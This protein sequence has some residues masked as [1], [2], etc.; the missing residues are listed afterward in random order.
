MKYP[1]EPE[2]TAAAAKHGLDPD[3][4]AAICW[5]ESEFKPEA[6]RYEGR[7]ERRYIDF[8]TKY[9]TLPENIQDMLASSHGL[10][11]VMGLTACELGLNPLDLDQLYIPETGLE[12][13]CQY[14]AKLIKKY[15]SNPQPGAAVLQGK[16]LEAVIAA[17]NAGSPRKGPKGLGGARWVN[18]KYVNKVV[19]KYEEYRRAGR[20]AGPTKA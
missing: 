8:N 12:Y 19:K 13:S 18:Y 6:T 14:L 11:Q 2:I 1:F 16:N 15:G 7:F 4:V 9:C 20:P 10:M 17:Y 3:L 5:K